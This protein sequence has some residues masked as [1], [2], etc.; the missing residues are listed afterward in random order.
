VATLLLPRRHAERQNPAH[1]FDRIEPALGDIV[2]PLR[3]GAGS[4]RVVPHFGCRPWRALPLQEM[5]IE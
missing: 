5:T 2:A 3:L 4:L 1:T